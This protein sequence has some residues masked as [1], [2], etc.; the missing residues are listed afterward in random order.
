MAYRLSFSCTLDLFWL[1]SI[2]KE[3]IK[4]ELYGLSSI[5]PNYTYFSY[6]FFSQCILNKCSA[7]LQ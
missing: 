4:Y 5:Y 2:T 7:N 1:I 3:S 6:Y